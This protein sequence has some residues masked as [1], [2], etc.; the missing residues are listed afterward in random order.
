MK[1]SLRL[2]SHRRQR[3][4]GVLFAAAALFWCGSEA[5]IA[6]AAPGAPSGD[7]KPAAAAKAISAAEFSRMVRYFSE[8]GGSFFSDNFVS[9]ET[10]YLLV[11]DKLK[12]LGVSG[13]A[14]V[15]VGPE[16]NF[17]YIAKIRPQIA[18]II[19]I[20]RAAIIQHLMYKAIFQ[21]AGDRA[22][23][24]SWLFSKPLDAKGA[25][26]PDASIQDMVEY[27][28]KA[29]SPERMYHDNLAAVRRTI[30]KD[31]EFPLS[32][33]D[34]QELEH[35]YGAFQQGNLNI[36]FRFD[37]GMGG[38]YGGF[39]T[40]RDL[41]LEKDLRGNLGNF[42][43]TEEDYEFVRDLHRK[44]RIIPVVGDFAGAKAFAAVGDYLRENGYTVS[45]L[46][47]SN[48]E[49]FLFG[50]RVFNLFVENV[51]RL[52]RNDR[53][54]IIRALRTGLAHPAYVPGHRMTTVLQNMN[55]FLK[56]FDAGLFPDY[57][58]L[59]LTDF[60]SAKQP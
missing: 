6:L 34:V 41:V 33:A 44:N 38:F 29:P 10:A 26:G 15:G 54:T 1:T 42:L 13:G 58:S 7:Q 59:A 17:T 4:A 48:V 2:G 9:N 39:P 50:D 47:V 22:H 16:Q 23:F 52:P 35:V 25:P 37:G 56:D 19:D 28:G 36:S 18:F 51:R 46:Y 3:L 49:Q 57:R 20:R 5:Q 31:F 12:Q 32:P 30:E 45:A 27:F 43:A 24:L 55:V 40:L 8:P 60:I 21:V 11:L 53:S 14:Y